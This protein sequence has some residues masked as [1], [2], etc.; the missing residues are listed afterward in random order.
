MTTTRSKRYRYAPT[1]WQPNVTRVQYTGDEERATG[2]FVGNSDPGPGRGRMRGWLGV[3]IRF[4]G[5]DTPVDVDPADCV[6]LDNDAPFTAPAVTPDPFAGIRTHLPDGHAP[7]TT[8]APYVYPDP[9]AWYPVIYYPAGVVDNGEGP[10]WLVEPYPAARADG[11][12]SQDP[13]DVTGGA[14]VAVVRGQAAPTPMNGADRLGDWMVAGRAP[15]TDCTYDAY[16]STQ[17]DLMAAWCEAW[18][19]AAALNDGTVARL[20]LE[21]DDVEVLLAAERGALIGDSRFSGT[22]N[23]LRWMPI[24]GWPDRAERVPP[25]RVYQLRTYR[26]AIE[27]GIVRTRHPRLRTFPADAAPWTETTYRLTPTGKQALAAIRGHLTRTEAPAEPQCQETRFDDRGDCD[28]ND[29]QY[30]TVKQGVLG[31]PKG[32]DVTMCGS[33]ARMAGAHH[34]VTRKEPAP[35]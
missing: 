5:E 13:I 28:G 14:G 9:D 15:R 18:A 16:V 21:A 35:R 29:A 25:V 26:A 22:I 34:E 10:V 17:P 1:S 33:H 30:R 31:L 12:D 7:G 19:L 6:V 20:G 3:L 8:R 4:D 27:A 2:T 32:A 11:S 24:G 23:E